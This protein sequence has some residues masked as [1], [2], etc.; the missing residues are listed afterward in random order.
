MPPAFVRPAAWSSENSAFVLVA[1][2]LVVVLVL[3]VLILVVVLVLAVVLIIVLGV[4]NSGT[5]L[6]KKRY[7]PIVSI[8]SRRYTYLRRNN[9]KNFEN[10]RNIR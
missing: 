7:G 10:N 3:I 8:C 6:S 4:H 1:L 5:L 9:R 2:V